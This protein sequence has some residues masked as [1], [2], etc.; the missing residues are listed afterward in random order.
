MSPLNMAR[1]VDRLDELLD[2]NSFLL[3]GK[4]LVGKYDIEMRF[5]TSFPI[6]LDNTVFL[7]EVQIPF[8]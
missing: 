3:H 5:G 2:G 1:T 4:E 8:L 7:D 6:Y